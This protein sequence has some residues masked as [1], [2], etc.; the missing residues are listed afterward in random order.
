MGL[1]KE[2]VV[3]GMLHELKREGMW[4]S[5]A[6]ALIDRVFKPRYLHGFEI[7]EKWE[8][9]EPPREGLIPCFDFHGCDGLSLYWWDE[10]WG[11]YPSFLKAWE[12]I[13]AEGIEDTLSNENPVIDPDTGGAMYKSC[14]DAFREL[15]FNG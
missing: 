5:Q 14:M 13:E 2:E 4:R 12:M 9:P 3:E 8:M 15:G 10:S 1:S 7:E 11:K 6:K